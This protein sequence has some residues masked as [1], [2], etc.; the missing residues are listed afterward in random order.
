MPA[1]TI[2]RPQHDAPMFA[3]ECRCG[4]LLVSTT[5]DGLAAQLAVHWH[6][7]DWAV[8]RASPADVSVATRW[9]ATHAFEIDEADLQ[10]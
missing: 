4:R 6:R 8:D 10:D 9:V 2:S 5:E 1:T 7:E 3:I